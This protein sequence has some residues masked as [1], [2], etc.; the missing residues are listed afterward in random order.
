MVSAAR[1]H[2]RLVQ[3]GTQARSRETDRQAIDYVRSGQLGKVR[4]IVCFANKA[5]VP[6]GKRTEP[7]PIPETVDYELWC[8]LGRKATPAEVRKQIGDLP[9]FQEMFDRYLAHLKAHEIDPGESLLGPWLECDRENE[10]FKDNAEAN[11]L[12]KGSYREP[13]VVPEVKA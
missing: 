6:I 9:A 1:K 12:V 10:C 3:V 2:N 13:F 4:Y 7:L 11:K 5:R 8:G